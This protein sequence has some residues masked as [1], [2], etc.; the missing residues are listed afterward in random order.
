MAKAKTVFFCQNC[1]AQSVKWIGRCPVCGEWN[2]Y[3][4]E[5]VQKDEPAQAGSWKPASTTPGGSTTKAAKSRPLREIVAEDEPR[6]ITADGELNR[7]LGG[8]FIDATERALA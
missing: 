6:I 3:V 8:G 7:V 2:T 4:E 1:G 5:V